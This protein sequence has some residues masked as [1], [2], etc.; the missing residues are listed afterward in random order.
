MFSIIVLLHEYGHYKTAKIFWIHIEEFGLGIPP[1]AKKLWKNKD[2]TLFSLNWIPLGWF[3]K[4]AGES[5]VF[6][7][8][9]WKKW[10]LLSQKSLLKKLSSWEDL[11]N[12]KWEQISKQETKYIIA[13]LSNQKTGQN[14]Y[15]KNIFAKSAVL[16]AWVMMNFLLAVV[17]FSALFFTW[18]K[19]IGINTFIE[20][21]TPSK[22]IPSYQ[23]ALSEGILTE[24]EW[25]RL[26]PIEWSISKAAGIM[27]WDILSSVNLQKISSLEETQKIIKNNAW[28]TVVFTVS[29][30]PCNDTSNCISYEDKEIEVQV[31]NDGL[32]GSYLSPNII[33]N[34]NF[35]YKY[36][37][38][39]SIKYG[40]LETYSQ[41]RLTF[42]GLWLLVK[43]I[44]TPETP[45]DRQEAI[46][47][48]AGPIGIVGLITQVM[49]QWIVM[50][51]LLWAIIS[52]N[53]WVFNL[54]PIPALDGGRLVL[55]WVRSAIDTIF[56]KN[57]L[58]GDIEN[59]V[60]VLF[61]L[62]LIALSI[63]IAY[64]DI[65]KIFTE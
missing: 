56:W 39:D 42:S 65:I 17:V 29:S 33:Q 32:I 43:N 23:Y 4:I 6:M 15:E 58:S 35:K 57:R 7:K 36:W 41:I 22:I 61:F 55:L 19:P 14:F 50:L 21:T 64:N 37:I 48:V 40:T 44:F 27:Q 54:L 24:N 20:T 26:F 10:K 53:L 28:S 34:E 18:V 13:R 25:I 63:V 30:A 45:Q 2:G 31:W 51:L 3:V 12:K 16:L 62:L 1:R 5:E 38:I 8:Y 9:Y 49:T 60:H 52:I 11:Y 59:S 47:S 46:E